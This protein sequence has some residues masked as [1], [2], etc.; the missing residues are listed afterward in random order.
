ME[1]QYHEGDLLKG[2]SFPRKEILCESN[3]RRQDR[4]GGREYT[5]VILHNLVD[6]SIHHS[7]F[8]SYS[9]CVL[10]LFSSLCSSLLC[11]LLLFSPCSRLTSSVKL[12]AHPAHSSPLYKSQCAL[13]AFIQ[14]DDM[15]KRNNRAISP[16]KSVTKVGL[17]VVFLS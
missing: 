10:S 9:L 4:K 11:S 8:I 3:Q 13:S 1:F 16:Q 7:E 5:F 2:R 6:G 14:S 12:V 17:S 15:C